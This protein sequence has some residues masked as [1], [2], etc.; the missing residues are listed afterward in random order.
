VLEI[1]LEQRPCECCGGTDLLHIWRSESVVVR[2]RNTWRF[3][4][5]VAICRTCGFCLS[6][7][8]PRAADLDQYHA[9]GLT[10]H[11]EIGLPYSVDIRISVL[12]RYSVPAGVFAEIGGDAPGEFHRLCQPLFRE[13]LSVEIAEDTPAELRSV[14]SLA[15]GSV[16][17]IAHYDVLEH[18]IDVRGFLSAC[19]RALVPGGVMICEVPDIRL[20][21]RNL[22]LFEF[23]HVNHF[24]VTTLNY[25]ARQVGLNLIE[26]GHVCSRP[27]GLLT[28]FRKEPISESVMHDG[29]GEFLDA[30]ACVQG[31]L[32]QIQRFE[33]Q[34]EDT[35]KRIA[36]LGMS[37][38]KVT[39]WAVTDIMRRMITGFPLPKSVTVVDADPRRKTHL[40]EEGIFV[41]QPQEVISHIAESELLVIC[42]ARYQ[43][44]IL[45]WV[46]QMSG[47]EFTGSR[48]LVLGA[49]PMGETL[50]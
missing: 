28:V 49:G 41:H 23:E 20:Y 19:Q 16:D 11:K 24:S 5:C 13:K 50:T 25:L 36:N 3:P 32:R 18:V 14:H 26:V 43:S 1:N 37:G 40:V 4:F 39:L 45:E 2:A 21:P 30:L 27:F 38:K 47:V 29:Q 48:L 15:E 35:R 8:G 31:G 9:E 7:P 12:E 33:S 42:A 17:V 6:S 44:S 10:G 34:I 46:R 22:L